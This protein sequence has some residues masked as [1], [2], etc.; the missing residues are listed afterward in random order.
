[1]KILIALAMLT[2]CVAAHAKIIDSANAPV[3]GKAE[4]NPLETALG[5]GTEEPL[6]PP[7]A[8]NQEGPVQLVGIQPGSDSLPA[9]REMPAP[10]PE[11]D[12]SA[13]FAQTLI[14]ARYFSTSVALTWS[15]ILASLAITGLIVWR[16]AIGLQQRYAESRDA[17]RSY[18]PQST[19]K[20]RIDAEQ[21]VQPLTGEQLLQFRR[22]GFLVLDSPQVVATELASIG[23]MLSALFKARAGQDEGRLIELGP[24]AGDADRP[25]LQLLE[26]SRYERRLRRL[27]CRDIALALARQVL[28]RGQPWSASTP[29]SIGEATALSCPGIRM[30]RCWIRHS[31]TAKSV[32]PS[33]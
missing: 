19:P 26:P 11:H 3:T 16:A 18:R 33:L 28:A 31:T 10:S 21:P 8:S 7:L 2:A 23:E 6:H 9:V 4:P 25:L 14:K 32:F 22:E 20:D 12:A 24:K 29:C 17:R 13:G 30:R 27:A 15:V 1:M 5:S